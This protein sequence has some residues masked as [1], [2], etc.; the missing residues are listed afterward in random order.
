MGE[1]GWSAAVAMV[2]GLMVETE[3]ATVRQNDLVSA[4][5]AM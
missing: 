2:A 1:V 4:V 3:G 5:V